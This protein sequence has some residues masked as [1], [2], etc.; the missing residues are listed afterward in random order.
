ME[1]RNNIVTI[2]F[3]AHD[4]TSALLSSALFVLG[5]Y[6]HI[7]QLARDEVL[8][9][10]GDF[11]GDVVPTPEQQ[12][13]LPYLTCVLKEVL[14]VYP[15]V[16]YGV[17][18]R[19]REDFFLGKE[20][21][22]VPKGSLLG[23][24]YWGAHYDAAQWPNVHEFDASRFENDISVDSIVSKSSSAWMPFSGGIRSCIGATFA[25][26]E[27]RTVLAMFLRNRRPRPSGTPT[28]A[29]P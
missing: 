15:S 16:S 13:N 14:R 23:L 5:K 26:A 20:R 8:N 10:L 25:Y 12:R 4:T 9:V 22:F 6:P 21:L 19:C 2:G 24:H 18:R 28:P 1:L 29:V 7:Q 3:A 11:K 17:F 27:A